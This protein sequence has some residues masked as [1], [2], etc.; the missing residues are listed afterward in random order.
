MGNVSYHSVTVNKVPNNYSRKQDNIEWQQQRGIFL[1]PERNMNS[2]K[3]CSL[4]GINTKHYELDQ[5][6]SAR[7][8]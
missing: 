4:S 2:Y 7:G 6:V 1:L 8:H 5:L 3:A